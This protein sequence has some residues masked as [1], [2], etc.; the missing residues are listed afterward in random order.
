MSSPAPTSSG[1]SRTYRVGA[2]VLAVV[3]AGAAVLPACSR[4]GRYMRPPAGDQSAS[5]ISIPV[6]TEAPVGVDTAAIDD[7]PVFAVSAPWVEGGAIPN[8]FTCQGGDQPPVIAWSGAPETTTSFAAVLID[9]SAGMD[10]A[11]GFVHWVVYNIDPTFVS[12]DAATPPVGAIAAPSDFGSDTSPVTGW[13]GPCP[14]VGET[15]SYV[16]EVHALDQMLEPLEGLTANEVVQAID[17]ATIAT[18]SL[19]AS[20]TGI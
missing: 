2:V 19:T 8:S 6:P 13:R 3:V 15:H 10:T 5:I 20:Y 18:A 11:V 7:G 17:A 1:S 12:L 14:P 16:L 9:L 4:D